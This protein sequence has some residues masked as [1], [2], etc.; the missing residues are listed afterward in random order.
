MEKT[1][2]YLP[3]VL[4]VGY[5][6]RKRVKTTDSISGQFLSLYKRS[7]FIA[8]MRYLELRLLSASYG[9]MYYVILYFK[10]T[11]SEYRKNPLRPWQGPPRLV[12][13]DEL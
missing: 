13:R 7:S 5:Y 11:E 3:D 12:P 8:I 9:L 4:I 1:I 6:S 10:I 2:W